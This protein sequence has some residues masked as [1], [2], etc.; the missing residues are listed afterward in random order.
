VRAGSAPVAVVDA[1]LARAGADLGAEAIETIQVGDPSR[2]RSRWRSPDGRRLL[3]TPRLR[4]LATDPVR[5]PDRDQDPGNAP[6]VTPTNLV[7]R[8]AARRRWVRRGFVPV[9]PGRTK[10]RHRILP[11]TVIGIAAML[12]AFAIG[13]GFSGAA[14]YAYY[15]KR[16]AQNEET[17]SRFVD[18]FDR[19]FTDAVGALDELRVQSVTDI[20]Q[21]L[22]PLGDLAADAKGV[23]GL[24]ATAG[25]SVWQLKTQNEV[26]QA[27]TGAAFAVA[28]H[29]KGT[30]F[31][32]SFSLV[33]ASTTAPSPTMELE[34]RGQRLPAQLWAWDT[35]H[36]LALVVVDEVVPPLPLASDVDQVAALGSRVFGLSGV[37]GQ[38]ATASPGVLLDHSQNGLQHT[39]AV[40][41]LFQGGPLVTGDGKVIGMASLAYRPFGVD[42]GQVL[43][44]PDV[45]ALCAKVLKC[46]PTKDA[47]SIDVTSELSDAPPAETATY[48]SGQSTEAPAAAGD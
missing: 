3:V 20:R 42:P 19:Q 45:A 35:E 40:G 37:G 8:A 2:A 31:I 27:V 12:L 34:K 43:Q 22:T 16:L 26:G 9:S 36:D 18:G 5:R 24:P 38:G 6:F 46:A 47:M 39:T 28:P 21:E 29:G 7:G 1:P 32:T 14:F 11:R 48:G 4:P 30:A 25:P 17:V 15:D 33:V 23:A 41:T 13:V 10:L 44:A